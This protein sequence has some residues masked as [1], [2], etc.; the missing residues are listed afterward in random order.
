MI[1][2]WLLRLRKVL[3]CLCR[4][5]CWRALFS[6]VAPSIEHRDVLAGLRCDLLIDVGANR[7]QFSLMAR[8]L[9][10][11]I[12]VHAFEPLPSEAGVY[13][14]LLGGREGIHLH[15]HALGDKESLTILHVSGHADSSSLLPIGALQRQLFPATAQVAQC[16]VKVLTLDS[17]PSCW[18]NAGRALLKLDV[19]GY[20]LNVLRGATQA[21]KH[22]AYVYAECS[23]VPLYDGQALY[24]EVE[25][26]L[27]QQGFETKMRLNEQHL[28]DTLVQADYL[29]ERAAG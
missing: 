9:D 28:G 25:A 20:E 26:F 1:H 8:L 22:C 13:R 3:F 19:Q 21:L 29:F 16:E 14:K 6:G 7:G 4:P 27:R 18:Q 5:S 2:L 24:P 10:A 11:G 15:E 12:T 23:H 17:L